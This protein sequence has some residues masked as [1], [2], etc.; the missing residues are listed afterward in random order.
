MP[1]TLDLSGFAI[2]LVER[3]LQGLPVAEQVDAF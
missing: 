3:G 2:T 1:N